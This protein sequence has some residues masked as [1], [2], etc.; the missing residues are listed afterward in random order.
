MVAGLTMDPGRIRGWQRP[1]K[2]QQIASLR[3]ED[4]RSVQLF[5]GPAGLTHLLPAITAG[6]AS[7][8]AAEQPLPRDWK[9]R[10]PADTKAALP[11]EVVGWD[12]EPQA[13]EVPQQCAEAHLEFHAR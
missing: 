3:C 2:P 1:G 12:G 10:E 5:Y 7:W 13:R 6:H 9:V 8:V 4:V 11:A